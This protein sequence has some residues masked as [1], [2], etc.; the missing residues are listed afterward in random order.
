MNGNTDWYLS[1][2]K[3]R[4]SKIS[5]RVSLSADGDEWSVLRASGLL[6]LSFCELQEL[7]RGISQN[8]DGLNRQGTC[9]LILAFFYSV[10]R[11]HVL[12]T[13]KRKSLLGL[14]VLE[15]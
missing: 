15:G 2:K 14:T 1:M 10:I 5:I 11:H 13:Y 6:W 8:V 4:R 3:R 12:H 7:R 9:G